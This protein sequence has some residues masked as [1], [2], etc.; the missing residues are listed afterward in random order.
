M[1]NSWVEPPSRP[2]L[3]TALPALL[4]QLKL[5]QFRSQW[6]AAE[7][8]AQTD[9][10]TP[11]SYLYV[12]AE[13]EHQQRHQAR[14]RRLLHEAQLPV[15]KTLADLDWGAIPD[16]DRHQIEQLAHDTGWLDR[17]ENLLLFGP[18]GVGKT[19][20]ADYALAKALNRLDRYAL[21]VIDDIGYVRK[22][23]AETSVLFE[24]VMH[25]Y[26]RRSLLVTSNQP[27]S[28]WENVFSTSAMTVA[29][30]DRL[31]DHS[32]IVQISGESYRR[33]RAR[34]LAP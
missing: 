26:E 30:V 23:E 33:K 13:Q 3:E 21:L 19:H 4:K 20:L 16:L 25:R 34:R 31:V 32:T 7:Q 22:D 29:A 6:Q 5:A 24:L 18:S 10:W 14:L 8:Q 1:T 15:P 27:F 2:A 17:A 9:G 11:A 12:L 28:E